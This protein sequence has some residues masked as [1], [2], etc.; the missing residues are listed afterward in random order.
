MVETLFAKALLQF[1]SATNKMHIDAAVLS[2]IF[3]K[4]HFLNLAFLKLLSI[5]FC[6]LGGDF[7]D[8]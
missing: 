6:I 5:I 4:F 8:L 3:F 7:T 2:V 1:K